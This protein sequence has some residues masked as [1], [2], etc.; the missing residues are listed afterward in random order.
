MLKDTFSQE[1]LERQQINDRHFRADLTCKMTHPWTCSSLDDSHLIPEGM[2]E[3]Q[4]L[5][6]FDIDNSSLQTS[7]RRDINE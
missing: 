4:E 3:S 6:I 1:A 7:K 5:T 2:K